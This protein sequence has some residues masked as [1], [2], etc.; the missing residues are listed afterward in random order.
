MPTFILGVVVEYDLTHENGDRVLSVKLPCDSCDDGYEAID[1]E[2]VY[3]VAMNSYISGGQEG[4]TI[5]LERT[6]S[7]ERGI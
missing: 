5:V 1:V 3:H 7:R 6:I 2:A 4:Y